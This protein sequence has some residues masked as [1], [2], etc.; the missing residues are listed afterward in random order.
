MSNRS[1]AWYLAYFPSGVAF[2]ILGVLIPLYLIEELQG[3][4]LDLGVMTCAATLALIPASVYLGRLPDRYSRSKPFILTSYLSAGLILVLMSRTRSVPLFQVLYVAMNIVNYLAGPSTSILIAES[5]ERKKWG[6]VMARRSFTDGL[7]QALGLGVCTLTANSLGYS[8]LLSLTPP[9]VFLSLIIAFLTIHDPPI[10]VERFLGR[11]E[12]PVEDLE[13]LSYH[14]TSRGGVTRP[15]YGSL[16]LAGEPRMSMFGVGMALFTFAASNA[17][18]SLPIYLKSKAG[19]SS[20]L[21]FGIFFARSLVG[22]FS[23]LVI[24]SFAREGGGSAVKISAAGRAILILLLSLI[25]TLVMPFSA[26]L[27]IALLSAIASCYSLYSL[28]CEVVT[29]QNAGSSGLGVYDALSNIG[30]SAG[31]FIGGAMPLLIGFPPLFALSSILFLTATLSF[32]SSR[33]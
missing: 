25:P 23:Y 27:T 14:M 1:S 4:L 33:V 10:Y 24:S 29:V 12:R 9:L 21:V 31:G 2:S 32:I 19:F 17:F 5:Y 6:K 8:T 20:S 15:R 7:A 3:S 11:V 28:G 22:T 26:I 13:T 30:S 18:T 16:S